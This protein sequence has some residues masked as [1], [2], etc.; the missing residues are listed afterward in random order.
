MVMNNFFVQSHFGKNE[1]VYRPLF[2]KFQNKNTLLHPM[3]EKENL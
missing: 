2:K 3:E 1:N